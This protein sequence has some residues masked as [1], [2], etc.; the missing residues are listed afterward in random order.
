MQDTEQDIYAVALGAQDWFERAKR[1]HSDEFYVRLKGSR[2]EWL[3]DAVREAHGGMLPNDYVYATARDAVVWI[4][5][6]DVDC[7]LDEARH[8]FADDVDLMTSD[9]VEWYG[10]HSQRK[11]FVIEAKE[12]GLIDT[13]EADIDRQIMAGQY[14]ERGRI[15]DA[16]RSAMEAQL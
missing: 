8:E 9:L 12:E 6:S 16:M 15:F 5:E 7:D 14:I 11:A 4:A 3:Q 13:V 1:S 2:P 10:S